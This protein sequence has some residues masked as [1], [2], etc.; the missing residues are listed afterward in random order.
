MCARTCLEVVFSLLLLFT[1]VFAGGCDDDD[2]DNGAADDD[3]TTDD[4]DDD[5]SSSGGGDDDQADDDDD[6]MQ[7]WD[8]RCEDFVAAYLDKCQGGLFDLEEEDALQYCQ[9]NI[10]LPWECILACWYDNDEDCGL[11]Y[12]CVNDDCLTDDDDDDD[13][14]DDN[15]DDDTDFYA[16]PPSNEIGVFVATTGDDGNPGTMAAPFRTVGKAAEAA[17]NLDKVVF[18]AGGEYQH[19]TLTIRVPLF[20]GYDGVTW[21]R[22]LSAYPTTLIG[23]DWATL[24]IEANSAAKKIV[25]EGF[26]VKHA[27][28]ITDGAAGVFIDGETVVLS[29]NQIF[30][31]LSYADTRYISGAV[32]IVGNDAEVILRRNTLR[33]ADIYGFY[34][35]A[36]STGLRSEAG[37]VRLYANDILPGIGHSLLWGDVS[38][39]VDTRVDAAKGTPLLAVN[40]VIRVPAGL[41]ASLSLYGLSHEG[42]IVAIGNSFDIDYA[43]FV[44]AVRVEGPSTFINNI[45]NMGGGFDGY[46]I[47]QSNGEQLV[48][49]NNDFAEFHPNIGFTGWASWAIHDLDELNACG[50]NGCVAA[51]DNLN[52][53]PGWFEPPDWHLLE[54]SPCLDAGL[55]PSPWCDDPE[56]FFDFETDSR[57]QGA[58]WDI[59]ADERTTKK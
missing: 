25:L 11:W 58:G 14:D 26:T 20:G 51:G 9:G 24:I 59:G 39:G 33:G 28:S 19:E 29:H 8:E 41:S 34:S 53:E 45:F 49:L 48:V 36:I 13:D 50:W 38:I 42:G 43:N 40:N 4:D 57:P 35:D 6:D 52:S 15:N 16:P 55:D 46:V 22:D 10:E 27:G 5:T 44:G 31:H 37:T 23:R 7:S 1:L 2:D 18:V 47:G 12:A 21:E 17:E 54:V 3:Q 56:I 32:W 30:A